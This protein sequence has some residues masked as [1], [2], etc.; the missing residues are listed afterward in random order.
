MSAKLKKKPAPDSVKKKTLTQESTFQN[1]ITP[2]ER[3][4]RAIKFVETF[5]KIPD[6]MYV[7]QPLILEEFQKRFFRD[8]FGNRKI[9]RAI[10]SMARK[11][12]KTVT[13]ACLLLV[14]LVGPEARQN[15]QIVSGAM[16]REQAALVFEA[17][18]KIINMNPQL[19]ALV[20]I[21]PSS[22][23]LIGLPMNVTYK[24]LSAEGKTAHGLSPVVVICDELGQVV[25]PRSEFFDALV[26][27]QGAHADPLLII[28]STQAATDADLLSI[29]IDDALQNQD[30]ATI[31]HLYTAPANCDVM[32]EKGWHDAN[33]ALGKFRSIE[34]VREQ[35]EQAKRMPSSEPTFRNLIL[36][37]R[38]ATNS[39]FVG[40]TVWR[41]CGGPV[42]AALP[43]TQQ[44][45]PEL[46]SKAMDVTPADCEELF[47]GL[48]LSGRTDLTAF[49]LYGLCRGLWY[50]WP[51]FWTPEKGLLE[52]AKRDRAPYDTWVNQKFMFTTP[53]ATVDY[54][55]VAQQIVDITAGHEIIG[56]AYDRWR[57]EIMRKELD[58]ADSDLTLIEWGQGFKD[59]GTAVDAIE[60]KILNATLRHGGHPVLTMCA[61][62]SIVTKDPAGNRK[63]DKQKT[64]GRIDGM[65]ALAMAAGYAERYHNDNGN[66]NDFINNPV[67]V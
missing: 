31:C 65:V 9:R 30:G 41:E 55:Y 20:K 26:T 2:S 18:C 40:R 8:L 4:A 10:W 66:I 53:G 47:G 17:C 49:V 33:P 27:S 14:F 35:A 57:I 22:K 3:A 61:A 15:A 59:M 28:I 62:N 13:I 54:E 19:A 63:L 58:R 5:C 32:D 52:R 37:Q 24:A 45:T 36:N 29:L 46:Y 6:G 16:S 11:N 38:V 50:C 64:S 56:V 42:I 51:Y 12:A 43:I 39:P 44:V 21:I 34:D 23:T 48:D 67:K 1:N 25:G 7:G 60:D